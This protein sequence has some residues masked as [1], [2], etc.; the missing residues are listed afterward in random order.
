MIIPT[1]GYI[2]ERITKLPQFEKVRSYDEYY[3][4]YIDEENLSSFAQDIINIFKI[5]NYDESHRDDVAQKLADLE[6]K[7]FVYESFIKSAGFK[8]PKAKE[9][10]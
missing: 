5:Y 6:A 9:S 7:V 3:R 2:Q 4:Y 1:V 8:L 10:K